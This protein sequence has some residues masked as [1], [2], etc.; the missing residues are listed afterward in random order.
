[1]PSQTTQPPTTAAAL[2]PTKQCLQLPTLKGLRA[3]EYEDELSFYET[4]LRAAEGD[5]GLVLRRLDVAPGCNVGDNFSSIVTRNTVRGE[6]GSGE[7]KCGCGGR[8]R[9]AGRGLGG[10]G[11][12]AGPLPA[13]RPAPPRPQ[14][15]RPPRTMGCLLPGADASL[16]DGLPPRWGWAL[17]LGLPSLSSLA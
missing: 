8:A 15:A 7:G 14:P 17:V 1:M 5:V 9:R 6:R 3:A 10:H 2:A 12:A 4:T 13:T 11:G 16:H